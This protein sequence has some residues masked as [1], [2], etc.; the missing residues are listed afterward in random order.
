MLHSED[1][2]A[3]DDYLARRIG[4]CALR[5]RIAF[6]RRW[7]F[8]WMQYHPILDFARRHGIGILAINSD[9]GP[10][11]SR[12]ARRDRHAARI[13][14]RHLV[15]RPGGILYVLAGD[16]HVARSHLPR[17]VISIARGYGAHPRAVVIHQNNEDLYRRFAGGGTAPP[18]V[19]RRG[20]SLFCVLNATPLAK[21][22]SQ[23]RWVL[24]RPA[25]AAESDEADSDWPL[26]DAAVTFREIVSAL[27]DHLGISADA[28]HLTIHTSED[29][30][31]LDAVRRSA[32][33]PPSR[34][35]AWRR[36]LERGGAVTVRGARTLLLGHVH[37]NRAAEEAAR[38]V[39]SLAPA[40][41]RG[42]R[43]ENF[44]ARVVEEGAVFFATRLINPKRK[45]D[46]AADLIGRREEGD[47]ARFEAAWARAFLGSDP[48]PPLR[49]S[50]HPFWVT[51]PRLRRRVARTIGALW[52]YHL[53]D[54]YAGGRVNLSWIRRLFR[55]PRHV[56]AGDL[57]LEGC[58]RGGRVVRV[59][60][61]KNL[62]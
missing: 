11:R 58:A 56:P 21:A 15:D 34:L 39:L 37:L 57:F 10:V 1:Q 51:T 9:P 54:A 13:L 19:V 3:V 50:G 60:S 53:F 22:Q 6:D 29:P 20:D 62:L 31:V 42:S 32:G 59:A 41:R 30:G 40:P 25:A 48:A 23:L 43:Q 27:A 44:Y 17:L 24:S 26:L 2:P 4:N 49:R 35:R 18:D 14:A 47:G 5:R 33:A 61:K 36:E 12:L 45:C 8:D 38:Y 7:G 16:W 55:R 52:G 46:L 28:W